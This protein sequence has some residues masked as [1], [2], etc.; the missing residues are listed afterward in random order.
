M[1][2][3]RKKS[4]GESIIH[5]RREM[6]AR[7]ALR[8]LSVRNITRALEHVDPP[9][10]NPRTGKPFGKSVVSDDLQFLKGEWQE[11]ASREI[12]TMMAEQY[13]MLRE[14]QKEAWNRNDLDLVMKAHDRI[15][16]ITGTNQPS[17]HRH[18]FDIDP[19][20]LERAEARLARIE[21]AKGSGESDG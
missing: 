11:E 21:A 18:T 7:L 8:G 5:R 12:G 19:A 3:R 17:K 4:K 15:A 20:L 1:A 6:V 2:S 13:A 10:V 16:A 14:V 9:I